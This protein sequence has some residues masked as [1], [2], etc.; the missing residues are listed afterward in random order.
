MKF[1]VDNISISSNTKCYN[2]RD[3]ELYMVYNFCESVR[4]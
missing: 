4:M 2:K 1:C 3:M